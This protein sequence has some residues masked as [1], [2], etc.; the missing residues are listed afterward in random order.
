M[1]KKKRIEY[2]VITLSVFASAFIIYAF[3]GSRGLFINNDKMKSIFF[4]G[5]LGGIG[6][7]AIVSSIIFAVR[8]F[9]K[10]STKFKVIASLLWP[11]TFGCV[12]Y[13]GFF[14]FIPYQIYNIVKIVKN[15]SLS[16]I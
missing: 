1:T 15:K 10:K 12:V 14:S 3:L 8:F 6:F 5:F 11:I 4:F 2:S 9:A 7:S 13:I 16:T